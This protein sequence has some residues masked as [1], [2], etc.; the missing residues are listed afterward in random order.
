MFKLTRKEGSVM[1]GGDLDGMHIST[2][3]IV[4]IAVDHHNND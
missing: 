3:C 4:S 1:K 2:P